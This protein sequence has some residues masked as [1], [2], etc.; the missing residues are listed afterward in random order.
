MMNVI[1]K[2]NG[3]PDLQHLEGCT[4]KQIED[5][6]KALGISFPDDYIAY[7]KAF[8]AISFY[9]TEWMGLN[10]DGYLNVVNATKQERELNPSFPP[11]FFVIE[12]KGIDGLIV[13]SDEQGHIY[14]VQYESLTMICETFG[15]YVDLCCS[16]R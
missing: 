8:G 6:E 5:A 11:N 4:N 1:E 16:Q 9:D 3:I 14:S 12:N 7:V 15:E 10:V 2:I 13:A